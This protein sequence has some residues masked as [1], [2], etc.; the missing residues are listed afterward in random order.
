MKNTLI[1]TSLLITSLFTFCSF[2][3]DINL[4]KIAKIK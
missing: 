4:D 3:A 2:G 1:K